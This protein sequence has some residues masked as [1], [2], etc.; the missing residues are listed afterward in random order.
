M[1]GLDPGFWSNKTVLITGHT[2]FKGT[3]MTVLLN[4]LGAKIHGF[5]LEPNTSPNIFEVAKAEGLCQSHKFSD[6]SNMKSLSDTFKNANPDIMI[7]MAA[8]PI[9]SKSYLDPRKTFETNVMGTVNFLECTRMV[10]RG[11]ALVISSDKCYLNTNEGKDFSETDPLGGFDPYSASKAGTEVAVTSWRAS[12]FGGEKLPVKLASARAGNVIGGGD[13]SQDRLLPDIARSLSENIPLNVRNPNATRPWQHVLEPVVAY[14]YLIQNMWERDDLSEPFNIGP[15]P[16][17][18]QTVAEVFD[19]FVKHWPDKYLNL[20]SPKRSKIFEEAK[21][22]SIDSNKI[23]RK[24][25]WRPVLNFHEAV[26][27][28]AEWYGTYYKN[29]EES[30]RIL[31]IRQIEKYLERFNSKIRR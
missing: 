8:Q 6:I 14:L 17:K 10:G 24:L 4:S 3:W 11:V 9:V 21:K 7:H 31:Q 18:V 5:A 23:K 16:P 22:L 2:G 20:P 12:F 25:N 15:I 13:W 27:W 28:S 26:E 19:C 1:R 29:G 30:A